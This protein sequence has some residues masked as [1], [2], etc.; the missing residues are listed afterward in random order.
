MY[1]KFT[2]F[3]G[4]PTGYIPQ[5]L[6]I[7]KLTTL[8]IIIALVQV[9]AASI[10]QKVTYTHKQATL[11]QLIKEIR[12][13]TG[14]NVLVSI[15]SLKNIPAADVNFKNAALTEVLDEFLKNQPYTYEIKDKTVLIKEKELNLI[16]KAKAYFA[17]VTVTGI[18][19]DELNQPMIG[20]TVR[21]KGTQNGTQTDVKGHFTF[22][23]P[24]ENSVLVFSFIGY[25]TQELTAKD[26][27][28]GSV[29]TL[30][31]AENNLKEVVV[32]KGYYNE[33]RELLTGDV[34]V[35]G[36]KEIGE[37][38]V[39]DPILALEGRVSGLSISQ[40]SGMPGAYSKILLRGQ[41]SIANGINPL[42]IVDGVP[43][44]SIS[45]AGPLLGTPMG[46]PAN[47]TT[48]VNNANSA[49]LGYSP[50]NNLNPSDIESIEV[51]KDA[52]ATA[53]YG[54]QGANGVILIT[55]KKGKAGQTK[56]DVNLNS[57]IGKVSHFIDL[58]TTQQ[59]LEMRH[60]AFKNDGVSP[61][62]N[63][64]YDINGVW[65]TTRYTNWQKVLIG[66]TA[67]FTTANVSVSGGNTNTQF[68]LNGG[69]SKQTTV[70]PGDFNDQKASVAANI[71]H[72]STNQKLHLQFSAQYLQDNNLLPST[73]FTGWITL[74]PD[75]P[76]LRDAN[77]NINFENGTFYS[78]L[79]GFPISS[80][81]VTDNL[82]SGLNIS[83]E[84]FKGLK[85]QGNFG[86]THVQNN[87]ANLTPA[88]VFYGPPIA[89][90]RT[91]EIGTTNNNNWV[92][93][94]QL[95]YFKNIGKGKFDVLLGITDERQ[96]YNTIAYTGYGFTSDELIA[97]IANA[98]NVSVR[99]G[100]G[101][102]D[103]RYNAV[104][105]RLNY[106]WQ[107]KYVINA[108]G[109]RDGSSRFG[110]SKQF[111]NFGSVG[112]AWLFSKENFIEKVF[113]FLS[114]GKLRASYGTT[115]NDQI[116]PYQYDSRYKTSAISYQN[117]AVL[118]PS[119]IANPYFAWEVVK[120][121]EFGLELG[122]VND[123]IF[124]DG[125][126]YRNRT[127]N[128]LVGQ[129]LPGIDGFTSIQANL[130]AVVQNEG[131]EVELKTIN[132]KSDRFRWSSSFNIS[133]PRN[134]LVSFP[135]LA[136]NSSYQNS[137]TVGQ[138]IYALKRYHYI[139]VDP[140][141]GLYMVQDVNGDGVINNADRESLKFIGQN[142]SGGLSNSF[143]YKNFQLDIFIQFVK[144]TGVNLLSST[145]YPGYF[146]SGNQPVEVL[147]RWQKPGD[148]TNIQKFFTTNVGSYYDNVDNAFGSQGDGRI[149][150]ASFIR[151]KNI[152]LSYVLP[153]SL[154]HA[155]R[156][157][158]AR[159]YL[160]GQNLATF[161]GYN[162]L[163][164]ETQGLS[165]PPLRMISLGM[166][167]SF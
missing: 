37:Q 128:Q 105:T 149:V 147:G 21:L 60:E 54:S 157:Q 145:G 30:K 74:P 76:A 36:A 50:F 6:R 53:I 59:Y 49:G 115:G 101:S 121:L 40:T 150:D 4:M 2:H 22:T 132:V 102:S 148:Q 70:F 158:N 58:L 97:N 93:E 88:T 62:P 141:T 137:Y 63:Y 56:V 104:Y 90:N 16:D 81:S 111:G 47:P 86:Y 32:S 73:D 34:S 1:K 155:L 14:Y 84:L 138:P 144:Q 167:A 127:G 124:V 13:Q 19:H 160:Q 46:N 23:V 117:T 125:S 164:P 39:S 29:I 66:N 113:P 38:P 116:A 61:D 98:S 72:I 165:L 130:P 41:N 133:A 110:P 109:R 103:Y 107:D 134:K 25:E 114:F 161:T 44:L 15:E 7:M 80:Q 106:S 99:P 135:G 153:Q 123:R 78:P 18:V 8:I 87:Q 35:V 91:I 42:Y 9:S 11:E 94:P 122:F 17:Q 151:L 159:I 28:A 136:T 82:V 31:V 71:T 163:D 100:S 162:G 119:S 68:R 83:Y 131:I 55:T 65:D 143:T 52:D 67:H 5:I 156:L 146:G 152:S 26:I 51:L 79:I 27:P 69:Y 126:Y 95:S 92:L 33:K 43:Y 64:D 3:F 142:F 96:Q 139:G 120:K 57:G 75:A 24:D 20:V 112:A 154:Q 118:T 85:I 140:Q 48:S 77:G 89:N 129:P 108:T 12:Q 10:A 45:P 166:Q